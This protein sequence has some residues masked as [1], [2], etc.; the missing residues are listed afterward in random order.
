MRK[1]FRDVVEGE[2]RMV[3][4]GGGRGVSLQVE[5][6]KAYKKINMTITVT[7]IDAADSLF[8]VLIPW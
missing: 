5:N 7:V 4:G 8:L 2:G 1:W 6:R 3:G